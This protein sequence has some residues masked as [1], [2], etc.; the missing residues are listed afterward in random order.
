MFILDPFTPL[1]NAYSLELPVHILHCAT[2]PCV[3]SPPKRDI[4]GVLDGFAI[5]PQ[6]FT[7]CIPRDN[8]CQGNNVSCV[9]LTK[10][11]CCAEIMKHRAAAWRA[12]GANTL[13]EGS[14]SSSIKHSYYPSL[15]VILIG[16]SVC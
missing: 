9:T 3:R 13:V 11:A 4:S 5:W 1:N 2:S 10:T 15:T 8:A 6:A 16:S 12:K 7:T 14:L